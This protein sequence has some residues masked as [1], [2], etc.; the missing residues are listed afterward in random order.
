[1]EENETSLAKFEEAENEWENVAEITPQFHGD[2]DGKDANNET[3][4]E[5]MIV[6]SPLTTVESVINYI[7]GSDMEEYLNQVKHGPD[8]RG[9]RKLFSCLLGPPSLPP[10]LRQTQKL[11]QA[12]AFIAFSNEVPHHIAM[13]RTLYRQLT[14]STLD[15]PR[16]GAHWED[17]GFQGSDPSTDLRGVGLLGLVQALYLVIT[18]E[19]FPFAQDVYQLSR[20]ESQ[21]FPLMVLSLNITRITL[22]VL[23]DGLLN[24]YLTLEDD[25]WTTVNFFYCALLYHVYHIWKSQ[26]KTISSSGFVLQ[27]AESFSRA[28]VGLVIKN[29]ERFLN[30]NYS[31]AVKQAARE[32]IHKYT[33]GRVG[34]S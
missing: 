15:C 20:Q 21:E 1:M 19:L 6:I 18:P 32:Q 24:R 10:H 31:V 3:A 30:L 12:T 16:Y 22:H 11:V 4:G 33:K 25:V 7:N 14:G 8:K 26:H 2:A 28:N 23:R 29:F 17:I 9:F 5:N 34:H 27:E 13:L